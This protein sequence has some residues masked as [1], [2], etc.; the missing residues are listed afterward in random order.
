M[1]VAKSET[2][3]LAVIVGTQLPSTRPESDF[4]LD[5]P[6]AEQLRVKMKKEKQFRSRCRW[7]FY[8]LS[9]VFFL[10]SVMVVSL[11]LTRGK[12]MFGSMI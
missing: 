11:V 6:R 4:T 10:L 2:I 9:V 7:F 1:T 8:F 3:N 5:L 12:R